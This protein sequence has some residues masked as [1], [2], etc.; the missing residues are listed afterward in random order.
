MAYKIKKLTK[1]KVNYFI[2]DEKKASKE[3]HEYGLHSL[4]R[5]EAKHKRYLTK[6]KR[7]G[8]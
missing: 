3:Y 4:A 8:L 2:K 6:L 5:D 1:K 7:E